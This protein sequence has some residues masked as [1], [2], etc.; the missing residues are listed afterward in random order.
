MQTKLFEVRDSA[1]FIPVVAV[2]LDPDFNNEEN[3]YLIRRAGFRIEP[4]VILCRLECAGTERNATYDPY[5]WGNR[6]LTTA[7][8]H[9]IEHWT[10]LESGAVIDVQFILKE[11]DRAKISERFSES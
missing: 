9:I 4:G 1:T 5:A 11:T 6:T 8:L 7:H 10:T 2:L 3:K